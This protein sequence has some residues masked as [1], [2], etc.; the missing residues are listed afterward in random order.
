MK[1]PIS[2]R[3]KRR[4]ASTVEFAIVA[5]VFFFAVFACIE[6]S[7]FWV[8]EAYV[9]SAVFRTAR[10]LSVFGAQVSEG[11]EF[12]VDNNLLSVVG[13]EKFDILVEP[14]RDDVLQ[15]EIDDTTTR[16]AVTITVPPE[17]ISILTGI[18]SETS[19]SR[20]AESFSNRPN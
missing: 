18:L 13:I 11:E 20:T 4:G 19:I 2:K 3:K 16:I 5:P 9:E 17:E 6:F 12:V 14:F 8:A 7:R 10:D 1:T 15:T